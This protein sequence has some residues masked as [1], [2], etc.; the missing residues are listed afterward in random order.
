MTK[1]SLVIE[2]KLGEVLKD[3][4]YIKHGESYKIFQLL[5][6]I[7]LYYCITN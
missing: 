1:P 3:V 6:Q 2:D 4:T 7:N 5:S